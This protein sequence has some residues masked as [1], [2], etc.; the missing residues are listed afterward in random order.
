[1]I[2]IEVLKQNWLIK[3]RIT[4]KLSHSDEINNYN[5]E[6][7]LNARYNLNNLK[8][9]GKTDKSMAESFHDYKAW[10]I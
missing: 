5:S 10:Y 6:K 8:N 4:E 7:K 2:I 9:C 3:T 1:M